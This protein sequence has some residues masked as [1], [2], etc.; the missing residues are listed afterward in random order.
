MTPAPY[1][2]NLAEVWK[3]LKD[4]K[5]MVKALYDLEDFAPETTQ[6]IPLDNQRPKINKPRDQMTADEEVMAYGQQVPYNL[7]YIPEEVESFQS[8]LYDCKTK[9]KH[10][11]Y[12]RELD[13]ID[14]ADKG[15]ADV[16]LSD[17]HLFTLK[18]IYL[19]VTGKPW[20]YH[21]KSGFMYKLEGAYQPV[22]SWT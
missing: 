9:Y 6:S 14:Y 16:R 8:F 11:L 15:F 21:T 7:I 13:M 17:K 2:E 12:D 5:R 20:P 22:W 19:K 4:I 3:E 18:K 1:N 10:K